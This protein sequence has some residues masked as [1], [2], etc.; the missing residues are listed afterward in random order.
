MKT[1]TGWLIAIVALKLAGCRFGI[2]GLIQML[3]HYQENFYVH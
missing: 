2:V 1:L 3:E